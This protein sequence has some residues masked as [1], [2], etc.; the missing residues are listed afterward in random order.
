[1]EPTQVGFR[2]LFSSST[3]LACFYLGLKMVVSLVDSTRSH[4]GPHI[5]TNQIWDA[6]C[7]TYVLYSRKAC[8]RMV[9]LLIQF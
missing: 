8:T 9:L 2:Y 6:F 7:V 5:A 4:N 3:N 1:M